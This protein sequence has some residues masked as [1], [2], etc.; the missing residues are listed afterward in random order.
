MNG[1]MDSSPISYTK[2]S[3][4]YVARRSNDTG[5]YSITSLSFEPRTRPGRGY[6]DCYVVWFS[7]D[8]VN[9]DVMLS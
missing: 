9:I 2:L 6:W 4:T 5:S 3:T 8:T 1:P 7:D